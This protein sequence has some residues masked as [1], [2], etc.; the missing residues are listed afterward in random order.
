MKTAFVD[1]LGVTFKARDESSIRAFVESL[2]RNWFGEGVEIEDSGR[3]FRGYDVKLDIPGIGYAAY[4]GNAD[5]L[6][7]EISG[8]GCAQV[9]DW[10]DVIDTIDQRQGKLT[11]VDVA[12]DDRTGERVNIAWAKQAYHDGQFNPAR[13]ASPNAQL[14]DDMGSGKGCT[15]YV[16]SRES[17]KLCRVY[18]KG[19]QQGDKTSSWVRVEVEYRA[20][21]RELPLQML[22]DPAAYLAGSYPAFADWNV[23]QM[24]PVTVAFD[25]AAK[26]E[27][28]VAH[29]KKQ[30]GRLIHALVTLN[31]GS[32]TDAVARIY[33][34]ELPKR[35]KG[36][37]RTLQSL[38]T[39][40]GDYIAPPPDYV[41]DA[42][43]HELMQLARLVPQYL[44][45]QPPHAHA[46]AA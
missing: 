41:R 28:A 30:A 16:G 25:N 44:A 8:E 27:K 15:L 2:L 34:P 12:A 14:I 10:R 22:R 1:F 5:T 31:G 33:R 21:H 13:G 35:L 11:R 45:P 37:V 24:R 4:G 39:D 17:G 23:E 32:I 40:Q 42:T 20:V 3:G 7:I 19:K 26:L 46:L 38:Q 36:V 9:R 6:H 18:E 43:P 29:A